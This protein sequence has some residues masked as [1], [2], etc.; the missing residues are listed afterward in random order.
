[1]VNALN[2]K[3][4]LTLTLVGAMMALSVAL[5]AGPAS[6]Q[7]STSP[8]CG[9]IQPYEAGCFG[10]ARWLYQTYGWGDQGGVC[11]TY[12]GAP[13]WLCSFHPGEGVYSPNAGSNI[14]SEPGITNISLVNNYVHGVALTH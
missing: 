4:R 12:R 9:G 8:Y 5:I 7:A 11:V 1:M 3:V 13:Q 10:A 2:R 14:W 6:A